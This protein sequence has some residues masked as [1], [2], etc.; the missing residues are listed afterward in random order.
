MEQKLQAYVDSLF[1]SVPESDRAYAVKSET[2]GR[3]ILEYNRLVSEG[4]APDEAYGLAV[5][6]LGD[7]GAV[8]ASARGDLSHT[9]NGKTE[10]RKLCTALAVAMYILCPIPVILL[11]NEIGV[12]LLFVIVA[13]ATG[14]IIASSVSKKNGKIKLDA[15]EEKKKSGLAKA[16]SSALWAVI[17]GGYFVLSF[18]TGAWHITWLVFLIGTALEGVVNAIVELI[19]KDVQ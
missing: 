15:P 11:Q 13:F 3:L 17:I 14:L 16:L 9:A 8:L 10:K 12:C 7:V 6:S 18:L 19:G 1:S 4:K 5:A 2:L